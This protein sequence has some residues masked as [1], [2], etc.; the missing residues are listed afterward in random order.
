VWVSRQETSARLP[1][2]SPQPHRSSY[3]DGLLPTR[4]A[5]ARPEIDDVGQLVPVDIDDHAPPRL[6]HPSRDRRHDLG[7]IQ[8]SGSNP[9]PH[10]GSAGS[11]QPGGGRRYSLANLPNHDLARRLNA[12][13]HTTGTGRPFDND[14]VASMRRYHQIP[15]PTET[16]STSTGD[17]SSFQKVTRKAGS[18][19]SQPIS[20]GSTERIRTT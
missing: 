17:G 13:G 9:L 1:S 6:R 20:R 16:S 19:S 2:L 3:D 15:W 8:T 4:L 5:I 10:R 18:S 11:R 12:A 7:P 14:A